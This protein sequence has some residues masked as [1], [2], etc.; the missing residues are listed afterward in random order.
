M[1]VLQ[2][3]FP[4]VPIRTQQVRERKKQFSIIEET[5]KSIFTL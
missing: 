3:F 1:V 4:H 2:F 5:F